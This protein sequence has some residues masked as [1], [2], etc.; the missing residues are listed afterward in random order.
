VTEGWDDL[1]LVGRIA[2]THGTRGAVIVN[3]DTDFPE[4]RFTSGATVWMERAGA[5]VPVKILDAWFHQGRPVLTLEGIGSMNDAEAI[6]G[7]ELRVP[8]RELQPLPD[9]TFY[10]F[11]LVGCDVVT[12]GGQAVG[13]VRAVDGEAGN[14]R[15]SVAGPDGEVL[16]PLV[17][18][19]CVAIDV[20]ARRVV[21]EPPEG[22]LEVNRKAAGT[23]DR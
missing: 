23:A 14:H 21:I 7:A 16:V 8:E 11:Q 5:A 17:A 13:T 22:L 18:P 4:E 2:R 6:R 12:T 1:V 10:H 15:L 9:G 19:I 20:G 3:P